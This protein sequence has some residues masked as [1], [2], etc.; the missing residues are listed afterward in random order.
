MK[1]FRIV[2]STIFGAG[3]IGILRLT[4]YNMIFDNITMF[5]IYAALMFVGW[6]GIIASTSDDTGRHERGRS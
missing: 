4:E 3:M 1:A 2:M 6:L 5:L